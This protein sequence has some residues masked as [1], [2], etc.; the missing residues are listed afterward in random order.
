[1]ED[2]MLDLIE[3]GELSFKLM[4]QIANDRCIRKHIREAAIKAIL[5]FE[6]PYDMAIEVQNIIKELENPNRQ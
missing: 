1:M 2:Y 6:A 4:K 3:N 5:D